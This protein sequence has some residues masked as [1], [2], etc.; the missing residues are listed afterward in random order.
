MKCLACAGSIEMSGWPPPQVLRTCGRH[1]EILKG[2]LRP[3]CCS[4]IAR[5]PQTRHHGGA[6]ATLHDSHHEELRV[7]PK[8]ASRD[9]HSRKH[10]N[11][12][13]TGEFAE[14]LQHY[15][16]CQAGVYCGRR[17]RRRPYYG[18]S[19]FRIPKMDTNRQDTLARLKARERPCGRQQQ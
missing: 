8:P 11:A 18:C 12:A 9:T 6:Q 2:C 13:V 19:R 14:Y 5:H 1:S 17:V 16:S 10:W 3:A 7:T 4:A 15:V